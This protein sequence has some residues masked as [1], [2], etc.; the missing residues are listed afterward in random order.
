[1]YIVVAVV[2]AVI[3]IIGTGLI[4]FY[5]MAPVATRVDGIFVD[6]DNSGTAD[7]LVSGYVIFNTGKVVMNN[8]DIPLP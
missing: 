5:T 1:M 8:N 3:S 2:V 4:S 6:I 7:Y